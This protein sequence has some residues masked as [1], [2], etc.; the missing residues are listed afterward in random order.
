MTS[1]PTAP[2][3]QADPVPQADPAP[4]A[5]DPNGPG[6]QPAESAVIHL[7]SGGDSCRPGE[8]CS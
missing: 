7:V 5:A 2:A 3:D 4:R 6:E 8:L 1:A